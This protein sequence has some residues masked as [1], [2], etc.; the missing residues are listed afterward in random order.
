MDCSRFFDGVQLGNNFSYA[1]NSNP[2]NIGAVGFGQNSVTVP[3][4][5]QWTSLTLSA[6]QLAL[7]EQP[8]S[9]TANAAG[10]FTNTVV[11]GGTPPFSYQWYNNAV[12][13]TNGGAFSGA[14]N[15]T[16]I[17]NPVSVSNAGT[18]Y[19]VVVT[20]SAYGSVTSSPSSL[21]VYAAPSF[22]IQLPATNS[23]TLYAGAIPTFSVGAV[24]K[25][26]IYYQ[27]FTNGVA[28]L[29]QTNS[30]FT[31]TNVP[32][33]V[34]TAY[35]VA[36]NSVGRTSSMVWTNLAIADSTAPFPTN[37]MALN[38][39]GYWPLN[40]AEVDNNG[41]DG[42]AAI[43]Y[44]GGNNGTYSN[45]I[46]GYQGYSSTDP[47]VT[48]PAF[49]SFFNTDSGAFGIQGINFG[50]PTNTST[51]FTVQAWVNGPGYG[52][53]DAGI[54]S[55]GYQGSEQFA[56]D[57]AG[58]DYQFLIH[59]ASG[60]SYS[61][62]AGFGPD[63][64][65]HFL[66]GVC[67]EVNGAVSLYVDGEL[68]ASV[69]IAAGS[70][71][72]ASTNS[73]S[74]GAR[75]STP[76]AN[77]DLQFLGYI[78]EVAVFNYALPYPR[79]VALE[80]SVGGTLPVYLAS[81]LPPTNLVYLANTT[82]TI[83]ATV[84]GQQPFGYYWS[85]L[86]TATVVASGASSTPA[87]LNAT[88]S[89]PDASY[90]LSGDELE[91][92]VTNAFGSTNW[93]VSLFAPPPPTPVSPTNDVIY[94][95]DFDGGIWTIGGTV[96]TV[97]NT[98][99][100]GTNTVWICT[101]TNNASIS[102]STVFAN[103]NLG[104]NEGS[105]LLPFTPE[106]GYVY[107]MTASLAASSA[108]GN[109]VG[110][111]F[112]QSAA[113]TNNWGYARFADS[114]INGYTWIY[115]QNNSVVFEQGPKANGLSTNLGTVPLPSTAAPV[116]LQIILNTITNNAWTA[117]AFMNGTQIGSNFVYA[118]PQPIAYAGLTQNTTTSTG[119][120]WGYWTL[121]GQGTDVPPYL[122]APLPPTSVT[123]QAGAALTIPATTFG[124]A[125]LGYYWSNTNT[126]TVIGSG[127]TNDL[128]ISPLNATLTVPSV[129]LNWNG[130][131][132]ELT[133]T[134]AYGTNT[135]LVAL[136]V[137]VNT[138]LPAPPIGATVTNGQ[139]TLSWPTLDTGYI[140]QAQTNSLGT[141]WVDVA[142]SGSSNVIAIPISPLN[143]SVFYRLIYR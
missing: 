121:T 7:L 87:L 142:G 113:Q 83:P 85:N 69:P 49:G 23:L 79:V 88:L 71:L 33:G 38:P 97:V 96:P 4:D 140:L 68:A 120:Q 90:N 110:M 106:P 111:G 12:P 25:L 124:A 125:P 114:P 89:I 31:W 119:I 115:V 40:E 50:A 46:L 98:L 44:A 139:L 95:N 55:E 81:P 52:V 61:A 2:T 57:I 75:S 80:E 117:S 14:T 128:S 101:Y 74:I 129:P 94:S 22:P 47:S 93:S 27:W 137:S 99:F 86:T 54:V 29:G 126:A 105:A 82:L 131:R 78:N 133:V 35:C 63:G 65:W 132:L 53:N 73:M 127:A 67:D 64:N 102:N 72:L 56:L 36:T 59:D 26:P 141:N 70:G 1:S 112:A 15:A 77:N 42:V 107:T 91:L 32:I 24:G 122:L 58:G 66:A 134:N 136:S 45:V 34:T 28:W 84:S 135:T 100:G 20:N 16:L 48:S 11:V 39:I 92:V 62:K 6:A 41:D 103:G 51:T 19:Y 143:G 104:T 8:A 118:T 123:V 138:N 21:V 10:A 116:T 109:L 30:S 108:M 5:Y 3:A 17:I 43:D 76:A 18:N 37:V 60:N 13:I 130:D 9:G